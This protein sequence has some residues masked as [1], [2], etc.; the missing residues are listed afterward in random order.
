[1]EQDLWTI[2]QPYLILLHWESPVALYT[3]NFKNYKKF[4]GYQINIKSSLQ[5]SSHVS[6][7]QSWETGGLFFCWW[8]KRI[9]EIDLMKNMEINKRLPKKKNNSN[10]KAKKR[11]LYSG[12][13]FEPFVIFCSSSYCMQFIPAIL[14]VRGNKIRVLSS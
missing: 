10:N 8:Y 14:I 12:T 3:K 13:T 6:S 4:F 5:V 9:Q 1:M 2:G 7:H 11:Q